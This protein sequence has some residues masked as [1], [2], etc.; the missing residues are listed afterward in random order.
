MSVSTRRIAGGVIGFIDSGA[1]GSFA[2]YS[3]LPPQRCQSQSFTNASASTA[4]NLDNVGLN[5]HD[6]HVS[7]VDHDVVIFEKRS[8]GGYLETRR[9]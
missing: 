8:G 4:M 2:F 5:E 1:I 7:D 3:R 9:E 6:F